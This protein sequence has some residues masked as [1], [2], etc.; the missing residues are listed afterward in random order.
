[1]SHLLEAGLDGQLVQPSLV[2]GDPVRAAALGGLRPPDPFARHP[3]PVRALSLVLRQ[4]L[5]VAGDW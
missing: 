3:L 2:Q 4:P 5:E 1:M